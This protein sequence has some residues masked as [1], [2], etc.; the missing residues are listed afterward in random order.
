MPLAP[1]S[2]CQRKSNAQAAS[3]R[4]ASD[5][6]SLPLDIACIEIYVTI[7]SPRIRVRLHDA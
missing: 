6:S 1:G 2:V 4:T 5:H 7:Y 3:R